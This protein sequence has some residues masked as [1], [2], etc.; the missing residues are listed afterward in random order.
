MRMRVMDLLWGSIAETGREWLRLGLG[1]RRRDIVELCRELLS[2]RGEASGTAL[3]KEVVD[4]WQA[5][6]A[7]GRL[8]FF[9][10]LARDFGVDRE[11][12][13]KAVEAWRRHPDG[14]TL[15]RL[16]EAAEPHRQELFRRINMAPGGT[17]NI[18]AMRA[19]LLRH[20]PAH[21]EL[22]EV[23]EDLRHL[24]S[25]WFNPGFLSLV[26]IDWNSPASLLEKIKQ[27]EKVHRIPALESLKRRLAEDRRCYAYFHP[28]LP[29]EPLIFVEIALTKGMADRIAPLIDENAPLFPLDQ[30][31]TAVFY[32]I[33]NC[34][35]GL[36]GVTLGNF[37]IKLV[38]GDLQRQ[39][40]NLKTFVTLSPL[41]TFRQWLEQAEQAG[42]PV[43]GEEERR[44]LAI[45]REPE[46]WLDADK[47]EAARQP[48]V[49]L[50]AWYLVFVKDRQGR[51]RD[52]VARFHLRNGAR[53]ER[54][55]WLAD[56]SPKGLRESFGIMVN[57]L[58]DPARIVRNH[59]RY[60][61]SG[62]VAHSP[63]VRALLRGM[64][65]PQPL[66]VPTE[67]A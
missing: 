41:P 25:S 18:V 7:D 36:R 57:Y 63:A 34:Q 35:D 4:A 20:L 33:N 37:L 3:A 8:A 50:C 43:I 31:D 2:A 64:E 52:P 60:V 9:L 12:L 15:A 40:P 39:L 26:R 30:A 42:D 49:R 56:T 16:R 44:A 32:S 55:N 58:Y 38:V 65:R 23:D 24:L 53:L 22:G 54:I 21:P 47:A 66:P 46:W 13:E 29:D 28:A 17:R 62:E 48:L 5:L 59:E 67:P 51:P 19:E 27:Y 11:A 61:E 14:L 6:D 45:L 10:T 1:N